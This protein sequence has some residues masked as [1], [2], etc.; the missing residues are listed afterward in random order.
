MPVIE[1][2]N[3]FFP[4]SKILFT[5]GSPSFFLMISKATCNLFIWLL[6]GVMYIRKVVVPGMDGN[7]GD[8]EEDVS[9]LNMEKWKFEHGLLTPKREMQPQDLAL[10]VYLPLRKKTTAQKQESERLGGRPLSYDPTF[11][12]SEL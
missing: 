7:D 11:K 9:M 12:R 5:S 10:D 3:Q 2:G 1:D 4:V 6:F 8:G